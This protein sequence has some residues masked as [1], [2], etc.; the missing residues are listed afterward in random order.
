[1]SD[2]I[3]GTARIEIVASLDTLNADLESARAQVSETSGAFESALNLAGDRMLDTIVDAGRAKDVWLSLGDAALGLAS[4]VEK[5]VLQLTVLN[6]LLNA[7]SGGATQLPTFS[8]S[9]VGDALAGVF[10]STGFASGGS[11][12]VG[13]SGGTDSQLVAFRA[14]PGE[15][16]KIGPDND[17]GPAGG[18]MSRST[19]TTTPAHRPPPARAATGAA[20]RLST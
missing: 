8:L 4:D 9:S 6:P 16:V 15:H 11:F 14:T 18:I 5:A 1:M 10:D 3:L 7:L 12:D 17:R 13:G 20:A 19:S 2:E